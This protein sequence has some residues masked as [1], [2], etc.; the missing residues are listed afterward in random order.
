MKAF[1]RGKNLDLPC[2]LLQRSDAGK[3]AAGDSYELLMTKAELGTCDGDLVKFEGML[4]TKT[5][6]RETGE[7]GEGAEAGAK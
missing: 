4:K 7:R 5:E 1:L 6:D 2:L 3:V